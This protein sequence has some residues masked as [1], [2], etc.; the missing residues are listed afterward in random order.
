MSKIDLNEMQTECPVDPHLVSSLSAHFA[1]RGVIGEESLGVAFEY[2]SLRVAFINK[3]ASRVLNPRFDGPEDREVYDFSL[4]DIISVHDRRRF[5]ANIFPML[6]VTESWMGDLVIR[7]LRGGDIPV[8][9]QLWISS[10]EQHTPSKFLFMRCD[11]RSDF[12][13]KNMKGW[14]D[15]ELLLALLAHAQDAIYFKDK[16]SRF[17]RAS[18]S[19]IR[20]FGLTHPHEIIGK[21]DFN[22]FGIAHAAE[23]YE[24]EQN[25]LK[26]KIPIVGKEEREVYEDK[27]DTWASTTKLPLYD[28]SG[29]VIG[30][31]GISRDITKKKKEEEERKELE[32]RLQL[33]QRLEAIGSLAAGVAH[34]INT[35]TQFVSDNVKFL[36]D[37]FTDLMEIVSAC[38]GYIKESKAHPEQVEERSALLQLIEDRD[39]DFLEEEIPKTLEESS[40]G[41]EQVAKI[42]GSMK[43]FSYPSSFEKG[44]ADINRAIEN[45]LNVSRNEWKSVAEIRL[46]L[47]ESL[48]EVFCHVDEL[49]QVFLNLIV[50]AAQAIESVRSGMGEICIK[51][52][53]DKGYV[54][55]EVKDTGEGMDQDVLSRIFEPFF[56]T[57]EVGKGTGQGLAMARSVIVERHG[58][59]ID[60]RSEY[61]V[62]S[63]F[64][65]KIPADEID[66][67]HAGDSS[68]N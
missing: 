28:E 59:E 2:P 1:G 31:F 43:E 46:E 32:V 52:S 66:A 19:M 4:E 36:K 27:P 20:R 63:V 6:K 51:T 40:D 39:L 49:K 35:P 45:T 24:D 53:F 14:Q 54:C 33:A 60:C 34:E 44:K 21:T 41:L 42:V 11:P 37:S 25:I 68:V 56:T 30:T 3:V 38:R 8:R 67:R 18:S 23:A 65:V 48:P 64:R 62:G 10:F 12:S 16:E 22:F 5:N 7:D 26:T 15:R 29:E 9:S 57:K 17:L 58:G 13:F 47:D 55:I 61:G 50:N